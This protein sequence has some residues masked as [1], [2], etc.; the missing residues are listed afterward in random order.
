[1]KT[2]QLKMALA[3]T[4][5]GMLSFAQCA[6]AQTNRPV[7]TAGEF[8]ALIGGLVGAF[9]LVRSFWKNKAKDH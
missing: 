4:I 8:G 1:M 5:I 3:L 6:F 2:R 7:D 9:F